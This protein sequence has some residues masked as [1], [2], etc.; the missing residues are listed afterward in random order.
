MKF[1]ILYFFIFIVIYTDS[2]AQSDTL[3]RV[4]ANNH[5]TGWWMVYLDPY[6]AETTDSTKAAY[7]KYT[8]YKGKFDYFNMGKIGAKKHPVVSSTKTSQSGIV[9]LNGDYKSNFK[10]GQT[11]F[12]LSAKN[13]KL[14]EYK[15]YYSNGVLKIRFDYTASCGDHP[16]QYCIYQYRKNGVLKH[17]STTRKP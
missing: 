3:N 7:L 16:F 17:T 6:L 10:N 8:Y 12:V 1:K 15:E 13:G 14:I 11:R 4:D 9:L 2:L 5:K